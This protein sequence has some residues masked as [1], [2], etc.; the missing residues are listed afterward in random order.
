MNRKEG[1]V[2]GES[3][4]RK[5]GRND[6]FHSRLKIKKKVFDVGKVRMKTLGINLKFKLRGGIGNIRYIPQGIKVLM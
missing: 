6:I 3:S 5:F 1:S 2:V 4:G